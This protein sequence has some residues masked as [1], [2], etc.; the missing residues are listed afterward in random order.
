MFALA[1]APL[2]LF[3]N[4]GR[5]CESLIDILRFFATVNRQVLTL[6]L[7]YNL[8]RKAEQTSQFKVL[9]KK[10]TQEKKGFAVESGQRVDT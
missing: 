7:K 9:K 8:K 3:L 6:F 1:P 5:K 4:C 2:T 10:K